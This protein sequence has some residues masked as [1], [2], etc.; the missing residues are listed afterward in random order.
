MRETEL[1][2]CI[3]VLPGDKLLFLLDLSLSKTRSLEAS[4]GLRS[5]FYELYTYLME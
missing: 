3:Y 1:K 5:F 2:Y 4:F